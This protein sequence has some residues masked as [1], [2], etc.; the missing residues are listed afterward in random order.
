MAVT[1]SLRDDS[2]ITGT[3][4]TQS[5][6]VNNNGDLLLV[7]VGMRDTAAASVST[8]TY[9]GVSLTK[10]AS[11]SIV[12]EYATGVWLNIEAWYL[13]GAAQ[14]INTLSLTFDQNVQASAMIAI[15]IGGEN[16]SPIGNGSTANGSGATPAVT[17]STAANNSLIVGMAI[18]RRDAGG[19]YT[20]GTGATELTE[21]ETG[22]AAQSDFTYTALH[23]LVATAGSMTIDTTN[24]L[25][26]AQW[27]MVAV[28][29]KEAVAAAA[30]SLFP[31]RRNRNYVR[32]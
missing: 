1:T 21:G 16:A 32:M 26:S 14:G 12:N 30:P 25:S 20:P 8:L 17:F 18:M 4:N 13:D 27:S 22:T 10:I 6:S 19:S 3:H 15:S 11:A 29:I 7:L 2:P 31:P 5:R 28:E 23:E 9:N 24:S